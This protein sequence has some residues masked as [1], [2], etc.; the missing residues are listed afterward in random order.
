VLIFPTFTASVAADAREQTLRTIAYLLVDRNGDYRDLFTSRQIAM[1]RTL[2]PLYDIPVEKDGWY[3]HEF[4]EGDPRTGLLTQASLLALHAHP[5]RTS[6]T[7]RGK[8]MREVFL[9]QQIPTPPANVNFAVVQ[10]VN[11]PTLRTTRARLQAHLDDEECASCHKLTDPIGLGLEQFDGAGQFR[12]REHDELIDV[13]GAFDKKPFANA[14]QLGQL[15]HDD[16]RATDCLV[17]RALSYATGRELDSAD[18]PEIA[19]LTRI[20]GDDGH[21]FK[22]LMRA[23][24]L[25]PSFYALSAEP[26]SAS[27]IVMQKG[28]GKRS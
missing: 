6:P 21:R 13:S 22:A 18:M 27:R 12:A 23:I 16:P 20:F 1:N 11:N 14:I 2:G 7:L 26:R 24:A 10:D 17:Q 28:K 9:C 3:I 5:G 19:Q 8:A 15:F 4:P 25:A